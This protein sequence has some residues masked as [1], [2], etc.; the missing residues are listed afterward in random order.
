MKRNRVCDDD[1]ITLKSKCKRLKKANG[2]LTKK[3]DA[4]NQRNRKI[5]EEVG[6]EKD[7]MSSIAK[8]WTKKYEV[9]KEEGMEMTL[10][11]RMKALELNNVVSSFEEKK[12][13]NIILKDENKELKQELQ[14]TKDELKERESEHRMRK[15]IQQSQ[16]KCAI[17]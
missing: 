17:M 5:L 10:K 9:L 6:E 7:E 8:E 14:R 4:A 16:P 3:L 12:Q 1:H 15:L 11:L 2:S 13:E